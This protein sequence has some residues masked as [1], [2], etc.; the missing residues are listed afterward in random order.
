MTSKE[1]MT[2]MIV[3]KQP[4]DRI[5]LYD[6]YWPETRRDFWIK[7][8]YPQEDPIPTS[9]FNYDICETW[10]VNNA[11]P[12]KGQDGLVE[13]TE[14]WKIWRDGFGAS[15]KTWKNKS[16]TPEHMDFV[17]KTRAD[18]DRVKE[19]LFALDTTRVDAEAA[20]KILDLARREQRF[21]CFGHQFC[22]ELMRA[23]IG[24]M[25]MLPSLLLEPDWIHDMLRVW[26]DFFKRHYSW[27]FDNIGK[28]DGMWIYEDLGFTNGLF[29]SPKTIRE[30]F[31][32]YYKELIH[33]YKHD[34]G[35]PCLI[36]T[37]GDIRQAVP[38]IIEAGWDCLQP[39]EAKAGVDV[40]QLAD[41]YGNKLAYMGNINVQVLN[42][43]DRDKVRAE[44]MRKMG[45]MIERRLPYIL[46]SDHS[47][48]PDVRM[49][50]YQYMLELHQEHGRYR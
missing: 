35:L 36:H 31:L 26:T 49:A 15:L 33:F 32:P 47:I 4:A 48:P 29:A 38:I 27:V 34:Y 13:E 24:D 30:L 44:V 22:I 6:H 12:L 18:W 19:P 20:R 11:G 10:A 17:I 3:H 40:L 7:E 46:H 42:T 1:R 5:G 45:G 39:M 50:T 8:G 43:N 41:T 37:C 21:S 23:T 25:V 28:P 16:G 14:E 9:Y 2:Q